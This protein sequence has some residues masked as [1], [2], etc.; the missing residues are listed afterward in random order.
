[1]QRFDQQGK[2]I[3][4]LP[5]KKSIE[6]DCLPAIVDQVYCS[7][8]HSL[9]EPRLQFNG[10]PGILLKAR[11]GNL[12]GLIGLSPVAGDKSRFTFDLDLQP[13]C[14]L[15]LGCPTCQSS[16]PEHSPCGCGASLVVLFLRKPPS[17]NRCIGICNRVDCP[18]AIFLHS[19]ELLVLAMQSI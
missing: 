16:L 12:W 13:G 10:H 11:Q 9:I 7:N 8:G 2:L 3:F 5:G 6:P 1:M 15:W 17:F 18:H 4:P 14:I 19:D